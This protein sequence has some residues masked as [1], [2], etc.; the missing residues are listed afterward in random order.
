MIF[1]FSHSQ[2]I[3]FKNFFDRNCV[4]RACSSNAAI[5]QSHEDQCRKTQEHPREV[6]L[7][8][9]ELPS[10]EILLVKFYY[11][12]LKF[13]RDLVV[14]LR[15]V[16]IIAILTFVRD[17]YIQS[18]LAP[19]VILLAYAVH[20]YALPYRHA[21][22]NLLE[23]VGLVSSGVLLYSGLA[24]NAGIFSLINLLKFFEGAQSTAMEVLVLLRRQ[25]RL[26]WN[27]RRLKKRI[28]N[29]VLELISLKL[30]ERKKICHIHDFSV[31]YMVV[32]LWFVLGFLKL[33]LCEFW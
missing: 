6:L 11:F 9:W 27:C 17:I 2:I 18:Y 12:L 13:I 25:D 26:M 22:L 5:L 4:K 20:I 23:T 31:S 8:I 7:L 19:I 32:I 21:C 15:K 3:H 24:F 30:K 29:S 28:W 33:Y 10:W 1:F 14:L 16:L